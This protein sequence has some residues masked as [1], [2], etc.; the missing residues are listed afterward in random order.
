MSLPVYSSRDF[1]ISWGSIDFDALAPD[2]FL[3]ITSNS[4]ITD[5]ETGSS[6]EVSISK[7]ADET[8]IAT[9]QTQQTA[10]VN[11]VLAGVLRRQRAGS[12]LIVNNITI[13]DP[14]G[15]LLCDLQNCH[16]KA[17]PEQEFGNTASGKTRT[18]TFFVERIVY[19]EA[20]QTD[21]DN[22]LIQSLQAGI[23]SAADT[24]VSLG[25]D[26]INEAL[27]VI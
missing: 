4:E 9:L 8:G 6:G 27:N 19:T 20:P 13:K 22:P 5:E 18:W 2:S 15:S 1:K 21:P 12:S 26:A 3:T 24:A 14:S 10:L 11:K 25:R 17:R 16:I 23:Q 7:L